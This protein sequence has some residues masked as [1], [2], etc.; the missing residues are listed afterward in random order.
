MK[1]LNQNGVQHGMNNP[2]MVS[3]KGQTST[4]AVFT[5]IDGATVSPCEVFRLPTLYRCI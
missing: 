2:T 5:G 4:F 3:H 1:T